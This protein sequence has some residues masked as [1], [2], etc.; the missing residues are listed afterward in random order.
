MGHNIQKRFLHCLCQLKLF[1]KAIYIVTVPDPDFLFVTDQNPS[2]CNHF[3]RSAS[4]LSDS[5]PNPPLHFDADPD[6]V[7]ILMRIRIWLS[8]MS[9]IRNTIKSEKQNQI[10]PILLFYAHENQNNFSWLFLF[11]DHNNPGFGCSEHQMFQLKRVCI[12][13]A[14]TLKKFTTL[15]DVFWIR[16]RRIHM[17]Q[18]HLDS[19]LF[20]QIRIFPS[21][22]KISKKNF[23]FYYFV[24]SF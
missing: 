18:G 13:N 8:K 17:S 6:Q 16:I 9:R 3:C 14:E 4:H 5:D 11:F 7:F 23:D 15:P 24:T 22:S 21:T 19:S 10:R 12:R 20:V 1:G 2:F